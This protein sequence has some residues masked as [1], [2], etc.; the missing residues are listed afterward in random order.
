M[1][2]H[3]AECHEN[4]SAVAEPKRVIVFGAGGYGR[5]YIEQADESVRIIAVVS[6][7]DKKR[8]L[9]GHNVIRPHEILSYEFDAVVICLDDYY[10]PN[11]YES[12]DD[13]IRQLHE[14]GVEDQRIEICN[15]FYGEDNPRVA[16]LREYAASVNALGLGGA[17]AECGVRR[18]HFAHYI[19]ECFPDRKF[20]MF[21]TFSGFDGGDIAREPHQ[22]SGDF[23]L[24][25]G[26]NSEVVFRYNNEDIALRRCPNRSQCV[27]RK[28]RVP[29]TLHGLESEK[30]L[31]VNLD[32]DLYAPTLEALRWFA[33]KIVRGG[34]I[35]CH[36]YGHPV[37]P[38]IKTAVD[39]FAQETKCIKF[40]AGDSMLIRLDID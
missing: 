39:K 23:M 20:Y 8:S 36:D 4:V 3:A 9:L 16:F 15:V 32:M 40:P 12:M 6:N 14:L 11:A 30:F 38:G 5:R 35:L 27:I 1:N 22:T 18:G 19:S 34:V 29:E 37:F 17:V 24:T 28:G 33:G 13:M 26:G 31:F 21:D 7:H 25:G 2:S 10:N